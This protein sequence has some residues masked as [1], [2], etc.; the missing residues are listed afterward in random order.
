MYVIFTESKYEDILDEGEMPT[1]DWEKV[2]DP[3]GEAVGVTDKFKLECARRALWKMGRY[4][5]GPVSNIHLVLSSR[6]HPVIIA[7]SS[8]KA[9]CIVHR[10][11]HIV[12]SIVIA[13][14]S[15]SHR[16]IILYL[17][18]YFCAIFP[19]AF[20][21]GLLL[22][23]SLGS[24]TC[25]DTGSEEE[26]P[27]HLSEAHVHCTFHYLPGSVQG[28]GYRHDQIYIWRRRR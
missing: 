17:S 27:E 28:Y 10:T 24:G 4:V 25:Q 5:L 1:K 13:V 7:L 19:G 26:I 2:Y 9:S 20:G 18:L 12:H 23:S 11:L 21:W 8:C 6:S 3:E 15:R 22:C 14:S 16:A